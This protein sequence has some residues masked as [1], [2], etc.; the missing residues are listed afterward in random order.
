M[1]AFWF[2]DSTPPGGRIGHLHRDAAKA[3]GHEVPLLPLPA[4]FPGEAG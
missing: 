3:R 2:E 4:D 1:E